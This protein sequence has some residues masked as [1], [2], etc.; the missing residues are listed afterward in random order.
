MS[1]AGLQELDDTEDQEDHPDI[2]R[3]RQQ[4]KKLE[5][6]NKE[7]AERAARADAAER[8]L[9]FAEAGINPKDPKM[10]YFVKGYEG[11]MDPDAIKAAAVEAGFLEAPQTE[12][13]KDQVDATRRMAEAG[14]GGGAPAN[15]TGRQAISEATS[16]AE[17][18]AELAKLG[19]PT[20]GS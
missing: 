19:V 12:V 1:E 14:A 6:E 11:E 7:L 9:A 3:Q 4:L 13:P 15:D 8:K 10:S 17:V 20:T 18:M 16:E 5:K 2:V